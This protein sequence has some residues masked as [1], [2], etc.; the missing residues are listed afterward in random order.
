[1]KAQL[2]MSWAESEITLAQ[3]AEIL[4]KLNIVASI[5]QGVSVCDH[6][7]IFSIEQSIIVDLYDTCKNEIIKK[8]WPAFRDLLGLTCAHI[9]EDGYGFNGCILDYGRASLCPH[10][11]SSKT[12]DAASLCPDLCQ[13]RKL[14]EHSCGG[15]APDALSSDLPQ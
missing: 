1:M 10:G 14:L 13:E 12:P 11:V 9:H 5:S 4:Q 6:I 3:L 8:I 15:G 7:G 2:R